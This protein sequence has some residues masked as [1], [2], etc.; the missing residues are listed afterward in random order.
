[1]HRHRSRTLCLALALAACGPRGSD[2]A[3]PTSRA[4]ERPAAKPISLAILEDYDKG[5]DLGDIARDFG[6]FRELGI[7]TWRGS[8]GWD[9]Y[10]PEPGRYDFAWLR[11]FVELA[12]DSGISLRPYIG[13]TPG[14]AAVGRNDDGQTWNDPPSDLDAWARFVDTLTATLGG[15]PH[16]LS[17]EI[18][19]EENVPLW[20]DGSAEEY[21][22]VLRAA[23]ERIRRRDPDAE[24]LLGG[25]VWPDSD[26]LESACETHGNAGAFDVAPFHAYP[27]TWPDT[28][29]LEEYL[30]ENYRRWYLAAI[31]SACGGKPVW[32][33]EAGFATTPG[34]PEEEQARWWAR[35]FAE[36]LSAPRVEHIG[37][38]EIRDLRPDSDV[39]GDTPNYFLGLVHA[40]GRRKLA[41]A[42]V[43]LL[44]RL[45]AGGSVAVADAELHALNAP[46]PGV[47]THL[48]LLPDERQ[49]LFAWRRRPPALTGEPAGDSITIALTLP[50]AAARAVRY[51]LDGTGAPLD[52]GFARR[53]VALRLS[54]RDV[55]IVEVFPETR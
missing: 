51:D 21:N 38:Y 48:F 37:V 7:T 19:N 25:T 23:A 9:D 40:D 39:I 24:I 41:F 8:F 16:V 14:W 45:F 2:P 13:Y 47:V 11:R 34:K 28:L 26:W 6:L 1:M 52:L 36:F 46:E 33:N 49:I 29:A 31:D 55:A 3:L 27:E 18:Y 4:P 54:S 35:A 20:W 32:I 42:T 22:A 12:A 30:D 53:R 10:E 50:R 44:A 15:Y 43:G 17:W 5:Q